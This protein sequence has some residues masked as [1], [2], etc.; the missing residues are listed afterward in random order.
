MKEI[1]KSQKVKLKGLQKFTLGQKISLGYAI[2]LGI[3]VIGTAVGIVLGDSYQKEA[4]EKE[5]HSQEEIEYIYNLQISLLSLRIDQ[6]QLTSILSNPDKFDQGYLK[7]LEDGNKAR[8]NW[9]ELQEFLVEHQEDHQ[10][11]EGDKHS[12]YGRI[13]ENTINNYLAEIEKIYTEIKSLELLESQ[14]KMLEF[15]NSPI[16]EELDEMSSELSHLK[17]E[18]QQEYLDAKEEAQQANFINRQIIILSIII[19]LIVA[20][21]LANYI[22]KIITYS[23][24]QVTEIAKKVTEKEDFSLQVPVI[25]NDEIS[26]LANYFNLLIQKMKILLDEQK[27]LVEEQLIK[28]KQVQTLLEEQKQSTEEQ[29]IQSEKMSSL[30]Q[31]LAGVAHEINN[32]IN[33]I[34]GNLNHAKDYIDDL[35]QLLETYQEEI[36]DPSDKVTEMIE[37]IDLEFLAEDLPKL[38]DSIR[39]GAERTRQIALSLR[40]FSRLEENNAHFLD[41]H[42]CI[43][44]TLLI[45]HNRIK[46]GVSIEKQ[47]G[48]IPPIEGFAG[49]LYQVFMNL[50]SNGIDALLEKE[51]SNPTIT[52][53]TELAKTDKKLVT[54]R[55]K[56]NGIG[57]SPENQKKIFDIFFTTKPR[58][59]G[60]GLG[61]AITREIIVDRHQGTIECHSEE[62]KGTEFIIN[63][64]VE[65]FSTISSNF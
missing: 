61:L 53:I 6:Q 33:F 16:V 56:D 38:I 46:K 37:E 8:I 59:I 13:Y 39:V 34:Y 26:K 58:G 57:I 29:L 21:I 54:V 28:T 27:L 24:Q 31:M 19:S 9:K 7:L 44:S 5:E 47:Y 25:G 35:F 2:A 52:I 63:L 55:I 15:S 43:D 65:H 18:A 41:I 12:E 1:E 11:R 32:P 60:T 51:C 45:L 42:E 17:A 10:N 36:T 64:P 48:N 4:W 14:T 49:S 62:G 50:I 30:G 40:N 20:V 3:A 23:L 22:S